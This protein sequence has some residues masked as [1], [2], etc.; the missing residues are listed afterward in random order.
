MFDGDGKMIQMI[1]KTEERGRGGEG[2]EAQEEG[3]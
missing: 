1:N 3:G 2:E